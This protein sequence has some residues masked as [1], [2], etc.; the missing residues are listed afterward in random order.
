MHVE[1]IDHFVFI[2]SAALKELQNYLK[3]LKVQESWTKGRE[4]ESRRGRGPL[5]SSHSSTLR[6]YW[7]G[8]QK[9]VIEH[10][11]CQL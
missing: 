1:Q 3:I 11:K 8:T 9:A 2:V 7:F 6:K 4:F 10:D 5:W